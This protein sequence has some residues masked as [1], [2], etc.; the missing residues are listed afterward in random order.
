MEEKV[1]II[2]CPLQ[3]CGWSNSNPDRTKRLELE[4]RHWEQC[5]AGQTKVR[6]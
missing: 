1:S 6:V 4:R 5:H 2:W 3:T